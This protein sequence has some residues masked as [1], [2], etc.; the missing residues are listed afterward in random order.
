MIFG[1]PPGQ[2]LV[3]I[4]TQVPSIPEPALGTT[5]YPQGQRGVPDLAAD[6]SPLSG[7]LVI[8]DGAFS[9]YVWGGTSLSA[10][11][12]AGMT[13]L[14]QGNTWFFTIGDL[15]PS[16]YQLYSQENH[17]F[18]VSQS[19]FSI[20]QLYHGVGGAMFETGSGQNGPFTVTPGVWNP[21]AGLGQL[22]V[23][24]LSRVISGAD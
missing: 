2:Q 22:N 20:S 23:Y 18:Y 8:Q 15:A 12:T 1:E 9:S 4:A 3:H 17:F 11:L 10:P 14:V 5:F 13:A 6:G 7:V 24:G 19:Q 21:V 16:L